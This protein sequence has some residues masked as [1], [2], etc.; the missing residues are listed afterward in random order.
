VDAAGNNHAAR[1]LIRDVDNLRTYFGRHAPAL[2]HTRYG[3]E[4]WAPPLAMVRTQAGSRSIPGAKAR[5]QHRFLQHSVVHEMIAHNQ[6]LA[7]SQ[8]GLTWAAISGKED[9]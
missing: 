6:V 3:P 7:A 1:M 2:L 5:W 8:K 9:R 4:I